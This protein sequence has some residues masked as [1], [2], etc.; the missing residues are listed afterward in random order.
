MKSK[1]RKGIST[2]LCPDCEHETRFDVNLK[3]P[4]SYDE[5]PHGPSVDGSLLCHKCKY[6][7]SEVEVCE[8]AEEEEL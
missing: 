8:N 2:M 6:E 1:Y 7:F 5:P 3:F 4:G